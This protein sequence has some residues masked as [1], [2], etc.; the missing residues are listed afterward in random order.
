MHGSRFGNWVKLCGGAGKKNPAP[1]HRRRDSGVIA[2]RPRKG[3]ETRS[4]LSL[5]P[6]FTAGRG[7]EKQ[8]GEV[9]FPFSGAPPSARRTLSVEYLLK[10]ASNGRL[11]RLTRHQARTDHP[12]GDVSG[13]HDGQGTSAILGGNA[14]G[15]GEAFHR[16]LTFGHLS[17]PVIHDTSGNTPSRH[18][19]SARCFRT[20]PSWTGELGS[21]G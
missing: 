17:F 1:P 18:E 21:C 9:N 7:R 3:K 14:F 5:P 15:G 6:L 20:F 8:A 19:S 10:V 12:G 16:L 2:S 11:R 4:G 13:Q